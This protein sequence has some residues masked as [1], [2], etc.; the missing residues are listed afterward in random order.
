MMNVRS[1]PLRHVLW[2]II[3]CHTTL[4]KITH[5]C[6]RAIDVKLEN[7][8][9]VMSYIDILVVKSFGKDV[10]Q[11]HSRSNDTHG[12]SVVAPCSPASDFVQSLRPYDT[13][14]TTH[15]ANFSTHSVRPVI[16]CAFFSSAIFWH[17]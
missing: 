3:T 2:R 15:A 14:R 11:R 10:I 5:F 1:T 13:H 8:V 6:C 4:D 12:V 7:I 16:L 9:H 17:A